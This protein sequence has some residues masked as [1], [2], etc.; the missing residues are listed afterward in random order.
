METCGISWLSKGASEG[1]KAA[2]E[3]VE[4]IDGLEKCVARTGSS[5]T[6]ETGREV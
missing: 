3:E 4:G 6:L 1:Q 2:S 5:E